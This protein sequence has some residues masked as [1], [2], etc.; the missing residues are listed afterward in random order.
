MPI[1]PAELA[2]FIETHRTQILAFVQRS[3]GPALKARIEAD[4]IVQEV[5]VSAISSPEQFQVEGRD[6]FRLL[7]QLCEQRIIDAHRRHVTS[8]KRSSAREVSLQTPAGRA[9]SGSGDEQAFADLL[10]ASITSPSAAFSR[11]QKEFQLQQALAE[12]PLEQRTALRLR[13]VD[14]MATKDIAEQLGKSDGAIRVMLSRTISLLQ[15]QLASP[16]H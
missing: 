11:H 4:D 2:A 1:P 12:L 7:C 3:L 15:E 6:P 14:G 13:F 10:I 5:V 8:Q 16:G 9:A